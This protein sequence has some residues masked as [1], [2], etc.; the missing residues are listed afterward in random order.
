MPFGFVQRYTVNLGPGLPFV[1][2]AAK[3]TNGELIGY[4]TLVVG[5]Q[6]YPWDLLDEA[7]RV[8]YVEQTDLL[9][10]NLIDGDRAVARIECFPADHNLAQGGDGTAQ[11]EVHLLA[12]A[13]GEVDDADGVLEANRGNHQGIRSGG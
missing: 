8:I 3:S 9:L 10:V 7:D 1:A 12:F 13:G 2:A 4:P 5:K 11:L 6:I